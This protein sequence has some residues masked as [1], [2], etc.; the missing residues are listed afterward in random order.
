MEVA[1]THSGAF[2]PREPVG[3]ADALL[4]IRKIRE[5]LR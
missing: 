5:E 2:A 3:G 1:D 4:V